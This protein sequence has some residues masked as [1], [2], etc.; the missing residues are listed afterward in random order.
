MTDLSVTLTPEWK[1]FLRSIKAGEF[2]SLVIPEDNIDHVIVRMEDFQNLCKIA[3][4][5]VGATPQQKSAAL[6]R[7]AVHKNLRR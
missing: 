7:A 2:K 4:V 5:S 6:L 1:E 3:K